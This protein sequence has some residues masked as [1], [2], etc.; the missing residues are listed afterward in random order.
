MTGDGA[1]VMI[2]FGELLKLPYV[3]CSNHTIHLAVKDKLFE[4]KVQETEDSSDGEDHDD[5]D[6]VPE[7]FQP[8][9][10]FYVTIKKMREIIKV[11]R[12]SPLKAG[13]L[14]KIQKDSGKKPLSVLADV[15]TRWNSLVIS[16][17]RFLEILPSIKEAL[18][19][20]DIRS[21]ISWSDHDTD[22]LEEI[23]S[24]LEPARA[25][26]VELSNSSIN[27]LVGQG[28]LE[29]LLTES[30]AARSRHC[31]SFLAQNFLEALEIRIK[32]RRNAELGTLIMYLNNHDL[33]K[34]GH[35]LEMSTKSAAVKLGIEIMNRI[36]PNIDEDE[37][38]QQILTPQSSHVSVSLSMQERL[39]LAIG[40]ARAGK[41][42]HFG[43]PAKDDA[44]K[45]FEQYDRRRIRGPQLDKL[46]D[47]LCSIQP[48]STQSER[49]FS[50]AAS[51]AT[52][53]RNRLSSEKLSAIM[54]LKCYFNNQ[55]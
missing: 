34:D 20:R 38:S 3:V 19:H 40:S 44:K 2:K 52:L 31:A 51:V 35:S 5:D 18:K 1:P 49:N 32:S 29:F 15:A 55:N 43:A 28:I 14:E 54:F 4:E 53:K 10:N 6:E 7:S 21:S 27:L 45:L 30:A 41:S 16:G 37:S 36:F 33:F 25:A 11:F 8:A 24:V 13:V 39:K 47:A 50:L 9:A 23:V 12:Y 48:T 46:F 26:T 22:I 17:K 42:Q